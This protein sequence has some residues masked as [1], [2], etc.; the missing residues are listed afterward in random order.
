MQASRVIDKIVSG[1]E[2]ELLHDIHEVL[3]KNFVL[4]SNHVNAVNVIKALITFSKNEEVKKTILT[5]IMENF[6]N[7]VQNQNGN[8]VIQ[9]VIEVREKI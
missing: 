2:D 5:K 3:L 8:F 7:L 1:L 4:L 9:T 6:L